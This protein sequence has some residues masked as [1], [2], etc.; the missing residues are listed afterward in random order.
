MSKM[1]S[2]LYAYHCSAA[3]FVPTLLPDVPVEKL[4]Q[5][6]TICKRTSFFSFFGK[7]GAGLGGEGGEENGAAKQD[8][9][10]VFKN[11]IMNTTLEIHNIWIFALTCNLK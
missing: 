7:R 9:I 2:L 10:Q 8:N 5:A 11:H 4:L 6:D 3:S 1:Q